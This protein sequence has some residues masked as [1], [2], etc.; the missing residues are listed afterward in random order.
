MFPLEKEAIKTIYICLSL[1]CETHWC[2]VSLAFQVKDC[3]VTF[4]MP[5][6]KSGLPWAE[7]WLLSESHF[8]L[9]FPETSLVPLDSH[10]HKEIV[11][12]LLAPDLPL[13]NAWDMWVLERLSGRMCGGF[14]DPYYFPFC[15]QGMCR[16]LPEQRW[17][18]HIGWL[19]EE[20][21]SHSDS[22]NYPHS[23]FNI[24]YDIY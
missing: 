7:W 20:N 21:C 10:T 22:I 9:A 1:G 16:L 11:I 24:K 23:H 2:H 3:G 6:L 13:N 5:R 17:Q 19:R 15:V 4:R 14:L 8:P 18:L 12:L